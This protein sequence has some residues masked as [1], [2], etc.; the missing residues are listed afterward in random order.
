MKK[1]IIIVIILV[2]AGFFYFMSGDSTDKK[3]GTPIVSDNGV[4]RP[5]PS[6][7]TFV[8][9]GESI[10]LS[11]GRNERPVAP[12]STL[13]EETMITDTIAYGD[14][15]ADDKEDTVLL[16]ARYGAGSGTFI[17]LGAYVSGPVTYRGS[18]TIFIGDRIAPEAIVI[19]SDSITV[20]YLDRAPNDA[21]SAEPTVRTTK[22]FVY[23][24]GELR[25]K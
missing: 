22:Q 3:T 16:L 21:F 24:A 4:L 15:N 13:T 17:Y 5:D 23:Q 25:E 6:N 18:N 10:T 14:I 11:G 9:E 1:L 12:G 7:A 20:E 8:F 2:A 19:S